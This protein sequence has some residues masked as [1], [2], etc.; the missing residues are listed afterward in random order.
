VH[1][2]QALY[3]HDVSAVQ[4]NMKRGRHPGNYIEHCA[5]MRHRPDLLPFLLSFMSV[6]DEMERDCVERVRT[7]LELIDRYPMARKQIETW[8]AAKS[9]CA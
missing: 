7:H 1:L 2:I 5:T 4:E 8:L 3:L 6:D 9:H